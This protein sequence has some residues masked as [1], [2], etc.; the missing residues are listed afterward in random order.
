MGNV[1]IICSDDQQFIGGWTQ[2]G[3]NGRGVAT[4][5]SGKNS[6]EFIFSMSRETAIAIADTEPP[7]K[8]TPDYNEDKIAPEIKVA[9]KI[10]SSGF[11]ILEGI[12]TDDSGEVFLVVDG[13]R[14]KV[15]K[16]GNFKM[17]ID[18]TKKKINCS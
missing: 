10:E 9:K 16:K 6:F 8:T 5:E 1:T 12:V 15:D 2:N 13:K 7:K 14:I 3:E 11:S 17:S 18:A 4:S